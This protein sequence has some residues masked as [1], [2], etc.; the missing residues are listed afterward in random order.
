[1]RPIRGTSRPQKPVMGRQG[2]DLLTVL[3]EDRITRAMTSPEP[4][5]PAAPANA[6]S[7]SATLRTGALIGVRPK[8]RHRPRTPAGDWFDRT[9]PSWGRRHTRLDASQ[10]LF[11]SIAQAIS[12][13]PL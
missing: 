8:V 13:H 11:L 6:F 2:G 10:G 7:M 9:N 5:L 4:R 1:M 12:R 3:K